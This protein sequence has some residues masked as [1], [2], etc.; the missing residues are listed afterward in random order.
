MSIYEE[1]S[2]HALS[3]PVVL[4]IG[5]FDGVHLGHQHLIQQTTSEAH[6]RGYQS[7]VVT[8]ITH[9][10]DV[11]HR[12]S[13]IQYITNLEERQCLLKRQG[14]DYVVP[15]TFSLE[16]S[17]Y[18]A[19]K[20][21]SLLC[22][23]LHMKGMVVGPDFALGHG[24]QGTVTVLR[25]MGEEMGFFIEAV[26]FVLQSDSTISSTAIRRALADGNVDEANTLLG[27][28]FRL[29][30]TVERGYGRGQQLGVPTANIGI[31]ANILIPGDGVYATWS[32]LN[33]NWYPS[34]TSIGIRPTFGEC[35]RTVETYMIDFKG[36]IYGWPLRLEFVR[37]LRDELS[38]PSVKDLVAQ[39]HRDVDEVRSILKTVPHGDGWL[40]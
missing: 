32:W 40:D 38:F 9:P 33:G 4:T 2:R 30:G 28:P 39:M 37:R 17:R 24:R 11:L 18:S 22:D 23:L 21:V 5:V 29:T 12:E 36:E 14:V 1:L 8:F 27:R 3:G 35:S 7:A 16:L 31:P 15:I 34:A 25:E 13:G 20:F 19:R 6:R 10:R 26:D